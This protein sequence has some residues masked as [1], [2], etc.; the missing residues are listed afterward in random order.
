MSS[1]TRR[2][3]GAVAKDA[4]KTKRERERER[5]REE[6][7]GREHGKIGPPHDT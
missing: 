3:H 2:S 5:E 1:P 6:E 7:R 4:A